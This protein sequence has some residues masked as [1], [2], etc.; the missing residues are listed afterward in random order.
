LVD[1]LLSLYDVLA[2]KQRF[3]DTA[4]GTRWRIVHLFSVVDRDEVVQKLFWAVDNEGSDR[5]TEWIQ[6]G[7]VRSLVE[8]A[9]RRLSAE[10]AGEI[11]IRIASKMGDQIKLRALNEL[12]NV[13]DI[14]EAPPNWWRSSYL[15]ILEKG[16]AIASNLSNHHEWKKK[17]DEFKEPS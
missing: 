3:N 17:A 9:A 1:Y 16:L 11:L 12:R 14:A 4:I 15:P 7:A 2:G 6:F 8:I 13:A 10:H 5:R